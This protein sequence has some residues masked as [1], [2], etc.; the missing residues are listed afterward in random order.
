LPDHLITEKLWYKNH[1]SPL[2]TTIKRCDNLI[3]ICQ[4]ETKLFGIYFSDGFGVLGHYKSTKVILFSLTD[5][6]SFPFI[7]DQEVIYNFNKD[8]SFWITLLGERK[9]PKPNTIFE[10]RIA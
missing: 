9:N 3:L 1:K 2:R 7:S 10:I 6:I 4:S 5:Q 8:N